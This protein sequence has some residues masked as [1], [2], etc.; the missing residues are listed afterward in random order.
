M[1]WWSPLIFVYF[2]RRENIIYI[3]ETAAANRCTARDHLGQWL[4]TAM[5]IC[6]NRKQ[7][8]TDHRAGGFT[9]EYSMV[10]TLLRRKKLQITVSQNYNVV[11]VVTI[12]PPICGQRRGTWTCV[13]HPVYR[14][15]K[16]DIGPG[17]EMP[18]RPSADIARNNALYCGFQKRAQNCNSEDILSD[19]L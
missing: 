12:L 17:R 18:R 14:H 19:S 9:S 3:H 7:R 16:Q 15:R 8:P 10:R 11:P 13:S 1:L 4:A 2:P 5:W 6:R